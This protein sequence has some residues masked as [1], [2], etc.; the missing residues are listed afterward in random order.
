MTACGSG[1]ARFWDAG[2]GRPLSEWLK[3]EAYWGARL[4]AETEH[5]ALGSKDGVMRVWEMPRAPVPV[6]GWFLE[7]AEAV[8]GIRFAGQA[9]I[10]LVPAGRLQEL[11]KQIPSGTT[12]T[13]YEQLARRFLADP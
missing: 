11:A 8:A 3:V 12:G 13:E 10:E 6:P 2:T 5:I 7:F 1:R 4:H 9:V